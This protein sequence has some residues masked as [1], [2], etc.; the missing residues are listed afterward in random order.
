MTR[1]EL[2]LEQTTFDRLHEV[3]DTRREKVKVNTADLV[4]LLMDYSVM[5]ATLKNH[6]KV[7]EPESP[8]ERR[9]LS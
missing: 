2:R 9:R 4:A 8:R 7:I 1:I 3:S 5:L 6:V